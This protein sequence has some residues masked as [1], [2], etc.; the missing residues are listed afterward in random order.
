MINIKIKLEWGLFTF[1]HSN[2]L[3]DKNICQNDNDILMDKITH[4]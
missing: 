2:Y 4:Y 3:V 1:P